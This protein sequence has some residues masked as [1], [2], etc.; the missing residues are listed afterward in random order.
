[1]NYAI[2]KMINGIAGKSHLLDSFGIF[3]SKFAVPIF[4]VIL[5][6][7]WFKN[8]NLKKTVFYAA[9]TAVVALGINSILHSM[10]YEARP[11][12]THHVNLLYSHV[13]DS[14]FPSDHTTGS[15]SLAIAVFLKSRKI[16]S[17]LLVFAVLVGWSRIFVGHHY[18]F[19]VL[20]SIVIALVI[21]MVIPLLY[22]ILDPIF[23]FGLFI[24]NRIPVLSKIKY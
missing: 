20:T 9:V 24:F 10:F 14:G 13:K 12:V 2:F 11:F 5:L 21:G 1:M 4:A 7:M 18:P 22:K 17:P 16:G 15:F 23:R 6:L 19:D 8:D 3:V